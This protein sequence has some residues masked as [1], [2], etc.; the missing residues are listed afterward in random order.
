LTATWRA[1]AQARRNGPLS[2][3]IRWYRRPSAGHVGAAVVRVRDDGIAVPNASGT[4]PDTLAGGIQ[5]A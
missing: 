2:P 1:K 3:A 4:A 5:A